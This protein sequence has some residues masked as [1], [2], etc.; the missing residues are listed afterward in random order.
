MIICVSDYLFYFT[1]FVPSSHP[2][3]RLSN[4][5]PLL[6]RRK[7]PDVVA[8]ALVAGGVLV[9]VELV[10]VL[11]VPPLARGDDLSGDLAGAAV[12]LGVGG[13]RDL[14]GDGLLLRAVEEDAAP[15]LRTCVVPLPV[16][17]RGVVDAV[18]ELEQLAVGHLLRVEGY[19][20]RLGVW[21]GE[22][23]ARQFISFSLSLSRKPSATRRPFPRDKTIY[24]RPVLPEHTAR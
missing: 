6:Q 22:C 14:A 5:A 9:K 17:G 18:E 1:V 3:T 24:S 13:G 8:G 12:P 16:A 11:G 4:S 15:V 2:S 21:S 20:R 10:V 7:V 19:L 23:I